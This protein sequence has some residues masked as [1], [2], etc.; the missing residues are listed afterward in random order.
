[1]NTGALETA[2]KMAVTGVLSNIVN[3]ENIAEYDSKKIDKVENTQIVRRRSV[4]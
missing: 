3:L 4:D 2:D 1:M